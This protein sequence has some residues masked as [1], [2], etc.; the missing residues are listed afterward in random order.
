MNWPRSAGSELKDGAAAPLLAAPEDE[1]ASLEEL[2][3]S[4]W[5]GTETTWIGAT[6]QTGAELS[7]Q[8]AVAP[9][10]AMPLSP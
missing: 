10:A 6:S 7:T 8:R 5:Y 9:R 4:S 2:D 1:A 3:D